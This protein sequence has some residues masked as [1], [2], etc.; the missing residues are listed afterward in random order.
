MLLI[1][2]ILY[3]LAVCGALLKPQATPRPIDGAYQTVTIDEDQ[4][5]VHDDEAKTSSKGRCSYLTSFCASISH[6]FRLDLFKSVQYWL[7][8]FISTMIMMTQTSWVIYFVPYINISRE[9]SLADA[10]NFVVVFG[11]GKMLG[12]VIVGPIV[13]KSGLGSNFWMGVSLLVTSLNF[14]VDPWLM[15]YWPIIVNV[16]ILGCFYS[17]LYILTDVI[18]KET[19]GVDQLGIALG[20]IGLK[21]GLFRLLFLFFPGM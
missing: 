1:G 4:G 21:G 12:T 8:T 13:E 20:W 19:I 5:V 16:F 7:I 14:L 17:F 11:T 6:T 9:Y 18:T 2:A 3:H 15:S 10:A